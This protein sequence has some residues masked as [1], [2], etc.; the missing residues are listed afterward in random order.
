MFHSV[1]RIALLLCLAFLASCETTDSTLRSQGHSESYVQGF[2]DGR[3]SGIKEA[4]NIWEHYVR[5]HERFASDSEY[6]KGW[7]AGEAE[8]KHLQEQAKALGDGMAGS[9]TG[10]KVGKEVDKSK[11]D[12]NKAAQEAM[13][14]MDTSGLKSLEK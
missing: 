11:P 2:H 1:V 3:H 13:K 12:P 14:G 7:K 8:G 4:G 6:Q 10:Y 9:Y 5:D